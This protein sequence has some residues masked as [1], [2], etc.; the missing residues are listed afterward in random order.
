MMDNMI[1]EAA[2]AKKSEKALKVEAPKVEPRNM[3]ATTQKSTATSGV[4][5][6]SLYD[7]LNKMDEGTK[8]FSKEL[9]QN[10]QKNN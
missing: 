2:K 10:D 4:T 5:T 1:A 9:G 6:E 3:I 8:D 7:E